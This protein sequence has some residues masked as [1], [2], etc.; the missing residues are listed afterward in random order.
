MEEVENVVKVNQFEIGSAVWW[1][2]VE[3]RLAN[4]TEIESA[5]H[6]FF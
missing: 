5:F 4:E 2:S 6:L 1:R 3:D